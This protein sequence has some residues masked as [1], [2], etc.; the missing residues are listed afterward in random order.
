[1]RAMTHLVVFAAP[2]VAACAAAAGGAAVSR[3]PGF[4]AEAVRT[5]TQWNGEAK[6]IVRQFRVAL[7]EAGK[8]DVFRDI[9]VIYDQAHTT[10]WWVPLEVKDRARRVDWV[11][12]YP[13]DAAR[14]V[15]GPDRIGTF[16][17]AGDISMYA[18]SSVLHAPSIVEAENAVLQAIQ[19]N[20]AEA[21]D[22]HHAYRIV[23]LD[24]IGMD[25]VATPGSA[26]TPPAKLLSAGRASGRWLLTLESPKNGERADVALDDDYRVVDVRR[27]ATRPPVVSKI[28]GSEKETRRAFPQRESAAEAIERRFRIALRGVTREIVLIYEPRDG[29]YWWAPS[30]IN[31]ATRFGI[32]PGAIASFEVTGSILIVRTSVQRA[33]T[34]DDAEKAVLQIIE[35]TPEEGIGLGLTYRVVEL[36][37]I[38]TA[39][40]VSVGRSGGHWLVTLGTAD[41]GFAD[42]T[43]DDDYHV[44]N[45]RRYR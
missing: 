35:R 34:I 9:F 12:G 5:F 29:A 2:F 11:S 18:R 27:T 38:Q 33:A 24:A 43:L 31:D 22:F 17:V 8:S 16:M 20:P 45:V 23:G 6:A 15:I 40:L 10:L 44:L 14:V 4:D 32:A 36:D 19:R 3:V 7:R 28:P 42:V 30:N 37:S 26:F 21:L 1:M 13:G 25:F 41:G 39:K